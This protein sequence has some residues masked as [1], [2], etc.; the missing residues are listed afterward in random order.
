MVKNVF[1]GHDSCDR[2]RC[3]WLGSGTNAATFNWRGAYAACRTVS[4]YNCSS[5][6]EG[7]TTAIPVAPG[8]AA[9]AYLL[10]KLQAGQTMLILC[11]VGVGAVQL[12]S[13]MG[14]RL[15]VT[16]T[17]VESLERLHQSGLDQAIVVGERQAGAQVRDLQGGNK[18]DLLIDIIGGD[19]LSD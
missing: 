14:A 15:I 6:L 19:A 16:G 4:S 13:R 7:V 12:A 18:V 5:I 11:G 10:G 8:T 1:C 17:R 9:W 3:P 2:Q